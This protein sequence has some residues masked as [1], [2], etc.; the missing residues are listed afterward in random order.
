MEELSEMLQQMVEEWYYSK[1]GEEQK[2]ELSRL[3]LAESRQLAE[4]P[5]LVELQQ[6]AELQQQVEFERI[7]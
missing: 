3:Q 5:Q 2:V 6:L 7:L 4:L 1:L